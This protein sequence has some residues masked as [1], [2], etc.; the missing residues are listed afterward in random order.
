[1]LDNQTEAT[2]LYTLD[3]LNRFSNRAEDYVKYRPIYPPEVIN[4]TLEGLAPASQL[5]VADIGAGTGIASRLLAERGV[6]VIAVEPNAAMRE[7][8]EPHPQIEFRNGSAETTKLPDTS[9]DL[10]TCFQALNMNY[11]VKTQKLR[12]EP[13]DEKEVVLVALGTRIK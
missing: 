2:L 7:A 10:V 5:I 9:V 4:I 11:H 13:G 3:P 1:M 8:A 6:N 12:F